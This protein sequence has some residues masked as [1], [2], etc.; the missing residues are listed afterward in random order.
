MGSPSSEFESPVKKHKSKKSK[1]AKKEK[2]KAKQHKHSESS[3]SNTHHQSVYESLSSDGELGESIED[4]DRYKKSKQVKSDSKHFSEPLSNSKKKKKEKKQKSKRKE[5]TTHQDHESLTSK[6]SGFPSSSWTSS[7]TRRDG[8]DR[9]TS[10]GSPEEFGGYP[11]DSRIKEE[12]FSRSPPA[13][14]PIKSTRNSSPNRSRRRNSRD[15]SFSPP[16]KR[17]ISPYASPTSMNSKSPYYSPYSKRSPRKKTH[18]KFHSVSSSGIN[19]RKRHIRD[20]SRSPS[21]SPERTPQL[22]TQK[23]PDPRKRTHSGSKVRGDYVSS[24]STNP[25]SNTSRHTRPNGSSAFQVLDPKNSNN[26]SSEQPMSMSEF[27]LRQAQ[28]AAQSKQTVSNNTISAKLPTPKKAQDT[29]KSLPPLPSSTSKPALPP[30]L[31]V[32]NL[33]PPPPPE[34]IRASGST[35]PPPLPPLPL[36]PVIPEINDISPEPFKSDRESDKETT[37]DKKINGKQNLKESVR[38]VSRN[39]I[40]SSVTNSPTIDDNGWGEKCVDMFEIIKIVGEGTYGQVY[41]AKYKASGLCCFHRSF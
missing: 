28:Q 14:R 9:H 37:N 41:K 31:P 27:F 33:P 5:S 40:D 39:S 6:Y 20:I 25:V 21:L 22:P 18:H 29:S 26:S 15:N 10:L 13:S 34:E 23:K 1:K 35:V 4:L 19:N 24:S 2:K 11:K 8:R 30:P 38:P 16:H 17:D 36:P 32:G 12:Y 7:S 3:S